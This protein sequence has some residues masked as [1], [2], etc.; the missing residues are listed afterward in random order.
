MADTVNTVSLSL[1]L[2]RGDRSTRSDPYRANLT[3]ATREVGA[4]FDV[5]V[6][7]R[8]TQTLR[9]RRHCSCI[10]YAFYMFGGDRSTRLFFD[11]AI[12]T[13]ATREGGAK[14]DILY[15][16][17]QEMFLFAD[18]VHA[19]SIFFVYSAVTAAPNVRVKGR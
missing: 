4:K 14:F 6:D 16:L 13:A 18:T 19:L 8:E 3:A 10:I 15:C 12:I 2:F 11:G 9:Y 7:F 17:T 1:C 5:W